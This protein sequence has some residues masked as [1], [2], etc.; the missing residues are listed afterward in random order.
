MSSKSS[1]IVLVAVAVIIVLAIAVP[2]VIRTRKPKLPDDPVTRVAIA[3]MT[4][5]L[6]GLVLAEET[7]RRIRGRYVPDPESAGHM[8]SPGVTTP[9]VVLSDTGWSATVEFKTIPGIKCAVAV[10]NRNP[11][12]RFA[13]SGQ[14]VCQ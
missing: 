11:L 2:L 4:S 13:K 12:D 6:R 14:I 3:S 10:Y 5:D 9:V 8:S 1:K 7:T